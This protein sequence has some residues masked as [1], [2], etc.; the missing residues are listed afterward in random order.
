M[1]VAPN[2][3]HRQKGFT[4]LEMLIVI[5]VMG[6]GFGLM[7]SYSG[8]RGH[9][10]TWH[11]VVDQVERGL[12]V[13]RSKAVLGNRPVR[14]DID[15]GANRLAIENEAWFTLPEGF[16]ISVTPLDQDVPGRQ[17]ASIRFNGDGSASGG[18]IELA[19]GQRKAVF[20]VD[21]LTGRIAVRRL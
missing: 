15:V 18:R 13:A 14:V 1:E 7:A 11:A 8:M 3:Q 21:W 19:G 6:L 20:Q 2:Q 10:L 16:T 17:S 4:L 9:T 5:T 12:H